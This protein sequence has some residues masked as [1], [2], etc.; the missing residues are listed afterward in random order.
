MINK[1]TNYEFIK[2]EK[3]TL[4]EIGRMLCREHKKDK[5]EECAKY[6][7]LVENC[8]ECSLTERGWDRWLKEE[9]LVEDLEEGE[10]EE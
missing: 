8:G 1:I 6:C 3:G 10:S 7:P 9:C 2:S 5:G 4:E